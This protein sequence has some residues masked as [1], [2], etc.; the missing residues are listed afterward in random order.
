MSLAPRPGFDP[1]AGCSN[2]AASQ[3]VDTAGLPWSRLTGAWQA[4]GPVLC[5]HRARHWPLQPPPPH[6]PWPMQPALLGLLC[7]TRARLELELD[8]DGPSEWLAFLDSSGRPAFAL[9]LLP[10]SDLLAWERL[11]LALDLGATAA[12]AWSFRCE[13]WR[14]RGAS[15]WC[16]DCARLAEAAAAGNSPHRIG[17]GHARVSH[18]GRRCAQRLARRFGARLAQ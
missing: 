1:D 17:L 12:D 14:G 13:R 5:L 9:G 10:D 15:D 11:V 18:Y 4:L 16:G 3:A 2:A 6:A 8:S 7:A